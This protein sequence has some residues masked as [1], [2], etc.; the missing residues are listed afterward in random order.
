MWKHPRKSEVIRIREAGARLGRAFT[1]IELLVVV[2]IISLLI[3]LLLPSLGKS[4]ESARMVSCASLLRQLGMAAFAYAPDYH[5]Y[6]LPQSAPSPQ[7]PGNRFEWYQNK[8]LHASLGLKPPAGWNYYNMPP[9]M[10]CPN[11]RWVLENPG[12]AADANNKYGVPAMVVSDGLH[13]LD[14]TYGMNPVGIPGWW[15]ANGIVQY[16]RLVR[17]RKYDTVKNP[18]AKMYMMDSNWS[19]P[20]YGA[21]FRYTENPDIAFLPPANNW[22]IAWR[23]FYAGNHGLVNT[24]LYDGHVEALTGGLR[25]GEAMDDFYLWDPDRN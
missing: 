7:G 20:Q 11:A 23:H 2:S 8:H 19:D 24:L 15:D 16:D 10:I 22:A 6:L 21:R 1:L 5:G 17:G 13:R 3:A 25:G 9:G 14:L 4:K 18:A 12:G